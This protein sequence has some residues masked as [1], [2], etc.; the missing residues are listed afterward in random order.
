[1]KHVPFSE[2]DRIILQGAARAGTTRFKTLWS[3]GIGAIVVILLATA[4]S[5]DSMT[6]LFWVAVSYVLLSTVD[7]ILH[8]FAIH[9]HKRLI[10]KLAVNLHRANEQST[11]PPSSQSAA[12]P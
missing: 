11:S 9:A 6:L 3:V 1:M 4:R 2:V 12:T 7:K 8:G 5:N 10:C